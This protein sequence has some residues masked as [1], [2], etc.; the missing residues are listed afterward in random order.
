MKFF[1]FYFLIF[2]LILPNCVSF[3]ESS[4]RN[5]RQKIKL[6]K[7][8]LKNSLKK[9]KAISK[10]STQT[11]KAKNKSKTSLRKRL[12]AKNNFLPKDYYKAKKNKKELEQE[13]EKHLESLKETCGT[14]ENKKEFFQ[15]QLKSFHIF[16][17]TS[18]K[19]PN[20][21]Y[22]LQILFSDIASIIE[23]KN[24]S[25]FI[26]WDAFNLLYRRLY[27]LPENM[28]VTDYPDNW[29]KIISQSIKCAQE[30]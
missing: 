17:N 21:D 26:N 15:N 10:K 16:L 2:S 13:F 6:A 27:N 25:N 11:K 18:L 19:D 4:N 1:V 23:Y 24:Y 7:N 29:A 3:N 30:E 12:L 5:T 20:M 28:E 14:T 8:N 22:A 9:R